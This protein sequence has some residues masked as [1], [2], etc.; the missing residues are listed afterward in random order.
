MNFVFVSRDLLKYPKFDAEDALG[1]DIYLAGSA[2]L[3]TPLP[4]LSRYPVKG[5]FFVNGGSLVQLNLRES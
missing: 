1:G 2:S 5:H 3:L 4:K